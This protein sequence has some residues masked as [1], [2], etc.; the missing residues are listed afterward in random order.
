MRLLFQNQQRTNLKFVL[1]ST[2]ER[3]EP[4]VF[5]PAGCQNKATLNLIVYNQGFD[6]MRA[7]YATYVN[8]TQT[9]LMQVKKSHNPP[10]LAGKFRICK[11]FRCFLNSSAGTD[12]DARTAET[13]LQPP[14]PTQASGP[15]QSDFTL[16]TKYPRED[17]DEDDD[18][19]RSDQGMRVSIKIKIKVT[20]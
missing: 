18:M 14:L 9:A 16:N 4:P 13:N 5:V 17:Q 3:K 1:R 10:L 7:C 15:F 8:V 11:V 2:D 19:I 20:P 12:A 6:A